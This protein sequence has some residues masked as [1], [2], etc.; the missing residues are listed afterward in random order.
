M[1]NT[2][3]TKSAARKSTKAT[4]PAAVEI[5]EFEVFDSVPARAYT[6]SKPAAHS[7]FFDA[8]RKANEGRSGDERKWLK[9]PKPSKGAAAGIKRGVY[10]A[11]EKGEMEA[12]NR[13]VDGSLE[14][15]VTVADKA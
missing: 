13:T 9:F 12:K 15:F 1:A 5:Q 8:V 11:V 3:T 6:L 14:V 7:A 4:E 2:A 10:A